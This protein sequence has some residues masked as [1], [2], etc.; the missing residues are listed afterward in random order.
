M[1]AAAWQPNE[2][3]VGVFHRVARDKKGDWAL[4]Y[5]TVTTPQG[6]IDLHGRHR[7]GE[8]RPLD[9]PAS[10]A[11]P[12]YIQAGAMAHEFAGESNTCIAVA[13]DIGDVWN[14][15]RLIARKRPVLSPLP[16]PIDLVRRFLASE[17]GEDFAL[18]NLLAHG[19]GVHHAGLPYDARTLIELLTEDGHL[20]VL[21]ATNTIAQGLNFPVSGI[22][23]A[24]PSLGYG[25]K[26][27]SRQFWNL[28]GRAGR[29]QHDSLGV[30]GLAAGDDPRA[31]KKYISEQTGDLISQLTTLLDELEAQG[32]L[33][34][35][36]R[37]IN[38]DQWAD[39]RAYVA[40]LYNQ[41]QG[42]DAVLNSTEQLL[43]STYGY[44]SLR[45]KTDPSSRRK[46]EALRDLTQQYVRELHAHPENASLADA[47]GFSPE[48]VRNALLGLRDLQLSPA[49]WR[50]ESLFGP[51]HSSSLADL[52]G[53]MMRVPQIRKGLADL[54]GKHGAE[55]RVAQ[56]AHDWVSG[57]SIRAIAE[58]YFHGKTTTDKI[59]KACREIYRSLSTFG[60]WGLAAISQL[61][62][63][64]L[65]F[66]TL[67]E[68]QK[69]VVNLLP[70]MIYHG[71]SSQDAILLRMNSVPRSL[72][73]PLAERFR[74]TA[75]YDPRS[76]VA[77]AAR[78][79][80]DLPETEWKASAPVHSDL[81]GKEYRDIWIKLRGSD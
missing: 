35:L 9:V 71:V 39:F 17:L 70:A 29:V 23:L 61:P 8:V 45:A 68:D 65:D 36:T 40:H 20:R 16:Q 59:S 14:M 66:S 38:D 74:K 69:R 43:R 4:E 37:V 5:E 30:V 73:E 63:S 57:R 60:S 2:R 12:L 13:N 55:E 27:S 25:R 19:I 72:A 3:L 26:L 49:A 62:T 56:V 21:C 47:T 18:V 6:T 67:S 54:A 52:V 22:F 78:F 41:K 24:S 64:G 32:N 53:V 1:G 79:L 77:Q 42:L 46:A 50:P 81:S 76:G 48:G 7:V 10:R 31:G 58:E 33:N 11:K 75:G 15:A 44:S 34:N 51:A 80:R 28:A